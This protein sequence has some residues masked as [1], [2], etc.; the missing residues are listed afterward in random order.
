MGG[1]ESQESSVESQK[2]YAIV[3]LSTLDSRLSTV[4]S[5]HPLNIIRRDDDPPA[6]AGVGADVFQLRSLLRLLVEQL[7]DTRPLARLPIVI[8]LGPIG[9]GLDDQRFAIRIKFIGHGTAE[10]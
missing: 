10:S 3:R 2:N 6:K 7:L 1:A 9:L 8:F 4:L 5:R